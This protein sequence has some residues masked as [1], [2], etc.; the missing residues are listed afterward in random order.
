MEGKL[1]EIQKK[2]RNTNSR[3]QIYKLKANYTN[4]QISLHHSKR[5]LHVQ[6]EQ[7]TL[8]PRM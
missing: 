2:R 3:M 5:N 6:S 7:I 1:E 8:R 4:N